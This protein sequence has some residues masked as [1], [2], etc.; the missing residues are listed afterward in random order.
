MA[1]GAIANSAQKGLLQRADEDA[2]IDSLFREDYKYLSL[3]NHYARTDPMKFVEHAA[4]NVGGAVASAPRLPKLP[5]AVV[6]GGG[7]AGLSA[8]LVLLDR[9]ATVTIIDKEGLFG[10]NSAW[11]SSG[12][13][14]VDDE[15][16]QNEDSVENYKQDTLK[17]GA[18]EESEL[19]S[20]LA[21]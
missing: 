6:V 17:S 5:D 8:A 2:L 12:I 11:A 14:A 10:G 9:G 1:I 16:A 7:L 15:T 19:I 21:S 4:R 18:L 20:V 3:A 13:N